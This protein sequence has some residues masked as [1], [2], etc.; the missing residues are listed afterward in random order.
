MSIGTMKRNRPRS[1]GAQID[2]MRGRWPDFRHRQIAGGLSVWRGTVRPYQRLYE[3]G[4]LWDPTSD[5]KPWVCLINPELMP[6]SDGAYE[7]IPHLLFDKKN[8]KWSGLCLFDPDGNEWSNRDL[9]ADTTVPW[10]V[11]WLQH[12]EFWRF[13]GNWRGKSI[14]PKSVAEIRASSVHRPTG[15]LPDIA[16]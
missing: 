6:R 2:R 7:K 3:I 14:G 5:L 12:Y 4:V 9:I 15:A 16:T 8:P 10:A 13:D 11:E 1:L